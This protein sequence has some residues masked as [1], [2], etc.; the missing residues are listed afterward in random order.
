MET[1]FKKMIQNLFNIEDEEIHI[2]VS[3]ANPQQ[4]YEMGSKYL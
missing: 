3:Y 2:C 1:S 4:Q